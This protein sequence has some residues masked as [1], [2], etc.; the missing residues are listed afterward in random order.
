LGRIRGELPSLEKK[1]KD[2]GG[3]KKKRSQLL[4]VPDTRQKHK[5]P[6]QLTEKKK[7]KKKPRDGNPPVKCPQV[8]TFGEKNLYVK[9]G[10]SPQGA[11]LTL[12]VGVVGR[13][14]GGY[15]GGAGKVVSKYPNM[16]SQG[17]SPKVKKSETVGREGKILSRDGL[18]E[19]KKGKNVCQRKRGKKKERV[20]IADLGLTKPL[21][22]GRW[23]RR[24]EKNT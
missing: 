19:T 13:V 3:K 6:K 7:K 15:G 1:K 23:R 17:P 24:T 14:T 4:K 5:S 22:G 10:T 8:R 9:G 12:F 20:H 18:E 2:V 16:L 11:Q 21:I